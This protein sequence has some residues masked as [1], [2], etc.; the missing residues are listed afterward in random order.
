MKV[1]ID[2]FCVKEELIYFLGKRVFW[3]EIKLICELREQPP[4]A[5]QL[6]AEGAQISTK[7]KFF[8]RRDANNTF[9]RI[10]IAYKLINPGNLFK[11]T[12]KQSLG[13]VDDAR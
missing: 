9:Q 10:L 3:T 13:W 1:E 8:N 11:Q 5:S 2:H 7:T 4:E 12:N 6:G